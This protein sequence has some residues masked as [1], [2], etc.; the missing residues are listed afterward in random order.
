M[1]PTCH[2]DGYPVLFPSRLSAR[3]EQLGDVYG[4]RPTCHYDG[5]PVAFPGG[6]VL[7]TGRC[8]RKE[9]ALSLWWIPSAFR[10]TVQWVGGRSVRKETNL[11]LC[12]IL[13]CVCRETVSEEQWV[14]G[15]SVRKET[16][17]L[18]WETLCCVCRETGSEE[19]WVGGGSVRQET[20]LLLWE[21][22]CCV[23]R[24]TVS[25]EQWAGWE[26]TGNRPTSMMSRLL[27]TATTTTP[28]STPK[29]WTTT[30]SAT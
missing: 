21:T 2:Y 16:N 5:H 15:R 19:Q 12:E 9:S 22:L 17:L 20:S 7:R 27:Q 3:N 23:C 8:V 10:E 11:L 6:T 30:M 26:V 13:C 18:L 1:R 4:K 24:E 29:P 28:T 14:G 25:E